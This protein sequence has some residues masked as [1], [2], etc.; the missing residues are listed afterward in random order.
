MPARRL[1]LLPLLATAG[2]VAARRRLEP[3]APE[4]RKPAILVPTSLRGP[5]TLRLARLGYGAATP[6]HPGVDVTDETAEVDGASVPVVVHRSRSRTGVTG[7]LLWIHGGGTVMGTAAQDTAR[8][9]ETA[10]R[11]GASSG[12]RR[13]ELAL[14][15]QSHRCVRYGTSRREATSPASRGFPRSAA[16]SA[17]LRS[18]RAVADARGAARL[19][20]RS[21]R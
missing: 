10:H 11:T 13:A 7:A 5:V 19:S 16:A 4:L 20:Q 9:S 8:C 17:L 21:V 6:A 1:L 15:P 14:V 3:V 2:V 18:H 12:A